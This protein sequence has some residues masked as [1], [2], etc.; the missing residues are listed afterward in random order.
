MSSKKPGREPLYP[1][2]LKISIAR[3]YLTGNLGYKLLARKHKLSVSTIVYFVRWYSRQYP[4]VTGTVTTSAAASQVPTA[5]ELENQLREANLKIVALEML[6]QLPK[7]S[8][9][10]I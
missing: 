1:D 6:M 10:S 3:E 4:A 8:W 2:S 7:R 9:G 5:K